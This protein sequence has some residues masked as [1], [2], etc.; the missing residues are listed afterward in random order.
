[1]V[2]KHKLSDGGGLI[3]HVKPQ[4]KY[5]RLQYRFSGKQ[6]LLALGVYPQ[7]SLAQA[8]EARDQA[9]KLLRDN[10][11][12]SNHKREEKRTRIINN[13]NTFEAIARQWH[14]KKKN[15]W[16]ERYANTIMTRLE[17]DLFPIIGSMP[18]K[19]ITPT[20]M[21][22]ALQEIEKRGALEQTRRAKQFAGQIF[23]YAIPMGLADRDVTADLKDA[24]ETR[25]T[26]HLASIDPDEL[27]QLVRDIERNDARMYPVTRFA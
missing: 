13:I 2:S 27:P 18:I 23:R 17:A 8:R 24:L 19:D 15:G 10:I 20:T 14:A 7:V 12:P 4:G 11:D 6:K 22:H 9:K 16:S 21:L 5:W 25:P 1:M 3:L 26:T